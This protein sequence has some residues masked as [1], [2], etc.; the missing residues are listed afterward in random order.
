MR[1]WS[2]QRGA[3]TPIVGAAVL[4]LSAMVLGGA[5]VGRLSVIRADSQRT[6][7][8]AAL[9]AV[10]IIRDRGLPLTGAGQAAAEAAGSRN[11]ALPVNY[12]WTIVEDGDSV[13]IEVNTTITVE[14][15][16][17]FGGQ[18]T[19]S[20]RAVAQIAQS[21]FDEADKRVPKLVLALDY[22]GS[23]N[24]PFV[25]GGIKIDV[26]EDS[27]RGLLNADLEVE[28][29]AAFYSSNVFRSVGIG[30]GA[31]ANINGIMNAFGAGG[32][33][34]TAAALAASRDLLTP[35]PNTG[36]HV[37]LVS[38]GAPCCAGNSAALARNVANTLWD[39][40]ITIFTLEIRDNPPIASLAQFMTDVA[41]SPSSR[42]DPNFHFVAES[43]ADLADE[44]RNI[45]ATIVCNVGPVTPVPQDPTTVQV[46]LTAGGVERP[47]ERVPAG[48]V[49]DFPGE[50]RFDYDPASQ[51]VRLS[52]TACDAVVD[53]GDDIVVR[54]DRPSLTE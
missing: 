31:P 6:A 46:Y 14:G 8:A 40:D 41:G 37:L 30:A 9:A 32:V 18:R 28:Y 16:A 52:P 12:A 33:T 21:R 29:G 47:V 36:Y 7:D 20:S 50:E 35:T 26:L 5:Y 27:V 43:A 51:I 54:F 49:G 3:I 42:R 23:M 48:T 13:D 24:S 1:R 53:A 4:A 15:P 19:V 45:I 2:S 10:Q 11:S 44:F 17:L 38:D 22:S 34:N 25:S 39:R